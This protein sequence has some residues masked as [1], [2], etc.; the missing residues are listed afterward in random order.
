MRLK[1]WHDEHD[2]S[3]LYHSLHTCKIMLT[4]LSGTGTGPHSGAAAPPIGSGQ[5]ESHQTI[6]EAIQL[7]LPIRQPV[8]AVPPIGLSQPT[9][10]SNSQSN[11][12]HSGVWPQGPSIDDPWVYLPTS[13]QNPNPYVGPAPVGGQYTGYHT[14]QNPP[15]LLSAPQ[16]SQPHHESTSDGGVW[17]SG[18]GQYFENHRR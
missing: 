2:P 5:P 14:Y 15:A 1:T 11:T 8:W 9:T 12:W 13:G 4:T 6:Q 7:R 18:H 3:A 10:V 17:T 16:N